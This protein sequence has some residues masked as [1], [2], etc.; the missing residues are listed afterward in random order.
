MK[1]KII[2]IT[3]CICILMLGGC[4]KNVKNEKYS[5]KTTGKTYKGVYTGLMVDGKPTGKGTFKKGT[6][7]DKNYFEYTGTFKNG[8][9]KGKG[10]IINNSF[11]C[12][13]KINKDETKEL[14]GEYEGQGVDGIP[15][16]KGSFRFKTIED[17]DYIFYKGEFKNGKIYGDGELFANT[18]KCSIKNNKNGKIE[19]EG[20]YNGKTTDCI[21]NGDGRF[22]GNDDKNKD[23]ICYDGNWNDGEISD[24]GTLVY[25]AYV[26]KLKNSK[27]EE[28]EYI[29]KYSGSSTKG[30]P[31]GEGVFEYNK[32]DNYIEYNGTWKNGKIEPKGELKTNLYTIV[33]DK[34]MTGEYEGETIDRLPS[35]KGVF[36][37]KIDNKKYKYD[38]DW[39]NGL[40]NGKGTMKINSLT[41]KGKFRNTGFNL[42]LANYISLLG[43]S[44]KDSDDYNMSNMIEFNLNDD[45]YNF[46]NRNEKVFLKHDKKEAEKLVNKKFKMNNFIRDTSAYSPCLI[47]GKKALLASDSC[48]I[49]GKFNRDLNY[50]SVWYDTNQNFNGGYEM[51]YFGK[52]SDDML[53]GNPFVNVYFLPVGIN[54]IEGDKGSKLYTICGIAAYIEKSKI[55]Y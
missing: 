54:V 46:I 28:T 12:S 16:G 14:V 37:S 36:S 22:E 40:F 33:S 39:K 17:K 44:F 11:K 9:I 10:K 23:Y 24:K 3:L 34:K 1:R 42:P 25:N 52:L 48:D 51:Y 55:V 18:Y 32:G 7:K 49:S 21:P 35:K 27:N 41:L 6:K 29:G 19:C 20:K 15:N 31:D 8:K 30:I 45:L 26:F 47:R 5:L 53:Y 13:V 50:L 4:K 38:G 43:T 2:I